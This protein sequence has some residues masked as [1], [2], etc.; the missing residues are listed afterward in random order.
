VIINII[1]KSDVSVKQCDYGLNTA[2]LK[3]TFLIK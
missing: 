2:E 1:I 3:A